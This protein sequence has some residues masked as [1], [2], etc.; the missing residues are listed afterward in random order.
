[1]FRDASQRLE[2]RVATRFAEVA[3]CDQ[4]RPDER[5]VGALMRS[6]PLPDLCFG[7]T[8]ERLEAHSL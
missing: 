7:I 5:R 6:A 3:R 2:P 4:P 8:S 1:V